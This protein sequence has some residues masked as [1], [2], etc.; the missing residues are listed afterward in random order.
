[1]SLIRRVGFAAVYQMPLY[2]LKHSYQASAACFTQCTIISM[3]LESFCFAQLLLLEVG[4]DVILR[5]ATLGGV[6]AVGL[7][8]L[9]EINLK[10]RSGRIHDTT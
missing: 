8:T 3:R 1:M 2:L 4:P 5:P 7:V 10:R 6:R 9:V